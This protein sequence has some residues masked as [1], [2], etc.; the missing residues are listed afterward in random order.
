MEENEDPSDLEEDDD[1]VEE[2]DDNVEEDYNLQQ[3]RL[4]DDGEFKN[5]FYEVIMKMIMMMGMRVLQ[6]LLKMQTGNSKRSCN[7]DISSIVLHLDSRP[8]AQ[9]Y[10]L[11][12]V[13]QPLWVQ[14]MQL[15]VNAETQ[16]QIL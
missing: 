5:L 13:D 11:L 4:Q 6:E 1:N 12:L 16:C 3:R 14:A 8:K 15:R 2:D 7:I 9:M 10:C